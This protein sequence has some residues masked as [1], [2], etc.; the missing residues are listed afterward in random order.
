[1][2]CGCSK[3][4]NGDGYNQYP[5]SQCFGCLKCNRIFCKDHAEKHAQ[6]KGT[7]FFPMTQRKRY[8]K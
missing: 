1:M 7:E 8:G 4:W 6:Y 3:E 2:S 5:D